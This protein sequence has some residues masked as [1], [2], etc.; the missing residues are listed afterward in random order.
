MELEAS[1][2]IKEIVTSPNVAELLSDDDLTTVGNSVWEDWEVDKQSRADWEDKTAESMKLALQV[3]EQKTFPWE[4]ASNVKFPIVTI[5]A[6]QYQ[7]RAYPSLIPGTSVVKARVIGSDPDGMKA[8]KASRVSEYMS[9]Q[10]L[11]EDECWEKNMDEVLI[12]QAI[13]GCAFKKSY[14]DPALGHNVSEHVLAKDLY[15]PYFAKSLEKASRITQVLYVSKNDRLQKE[16]SGLYL[17]LKTETDPMPE[18]SGVLEVVTQESQGL[19]PT[20]QD[21]SAP[22]EYLE[23]HRYLDL[24]GDGYEEPYIVTIDKETKQVVR[25]V[26]RFTSTKVQKNR[27]GEIVHI[28]PTHYFTKF[29]FIPSPDGGIYDLGF[30]VLLGPLNESINTI[31]NQLVDAGTLS[32]TAGGFLG[33]GVKFRSGDNSFRPFEWKR[34]D[35][36]GDDL[37]KGIVPLTVREPS[38]VLFQLLGL[39]IDY[40][41][42]IGMATDPMVGVNP[43]QNT[44]AETSRNMLQEGQRIFSAV[45]KRT[46]RSLKEEFRKLYNLNSIYLNDET[47]FHSLSTGFDTKVLREDFLGNGKEVLPAADPNMVTKDQKLMQAMT[48]KQNAMASPGM[49]NSYLVEK[50]LLEAMEIEDIESILPDPNGPNAI[51]AQ[52]D[53][54]IVVETMKIEQKNMQFKM[55]MQMK[56]FDMMQEIEYLRAEII[57]KESRAALNMAMAEGQQDNLQI[58]ALQTAVAMAK[59]KQDGLIGALNVLKDLAGF[60]KEK[61]GLIDGISG[62]MAGMEKTPDDGGVVQVSGKPTEKA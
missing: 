11:E 25:I 12:S 26:A 55:E 1:L 62:G 44:P 16:R 28:E 37:R 46:Y 8:A 56:M 61:K 42:R 18:T 47:A 19:I 7:S 53:A 17:P 15:I 49:Y 6:L 43:G 50:K 3:V 14:F 5:A 38:Q 24:D 29:T 22:R 45:F 59:A 35:S 57:E 58:T 41:E 9:F 32:N 33:R 30:G 2:E 51:P 27:K 10:V 20:A 13:V 40:G 23:Q 31:L 54:K 4:N 21:S 52:P 48:L 60:S 39:L 36:T 34:V